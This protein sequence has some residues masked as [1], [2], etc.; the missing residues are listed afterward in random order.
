[1]TK[2]FYLNLKKQIISFGFQD[3]IT[4]AEGL[5]PCKTAFNFWREFTFVVCNSGMKWE[6]GSSIYNK[7]MD[8]YARGKKARSVFGHA[9][10]AAA[11][12]EVY[13]NRCRY[14]I[15]YLAA[16]DKL[17]YCESLPWIGPITKYHLAKNLG[18][19]CCK[20]DRHLVRQAEKYN[21]TPAALCKKLSEETGDRVVTVDT[22][23]WRAAALG[24]IK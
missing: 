24:V 9:G 16:D 21:T 22:V 8:A 19:D 15:E 6:I 4:W 10:K 3:D 2:E 20:P 13:E 17:K 1:M 7:I 23:I 12:H 18:M 5:E 11:I 14:F